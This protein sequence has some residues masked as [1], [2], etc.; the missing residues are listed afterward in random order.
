MRIT[1]LSAL[2]RQIMSELDE[3]GFPTEED[4]KM[5]T[6]GILRIQHVYDL[7]TDDVSFLCTLKV[8]LKR[9]SVA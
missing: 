1:K 2:R 6:S 7:S 9:S 8:T 5:A 3:L 4:Y